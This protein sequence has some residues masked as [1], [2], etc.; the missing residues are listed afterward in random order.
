M[1]RK[2]VFEKLAERRLTMKEASL[3]MGRA[4]SYLYQFLKR[5]IP[6]ELHER[7]RIS[8]AAILEVPEGEL[9]GPSM[10]LPKR[11]Y[12]KVAAS[13]KSLIDGDSMSVPSSVESHPANLVSSADLFGGRH[14]LPVFGASQTEQGGQLIVSDAAVDWVARPAMLQ[15]VNDGYGLI[16]PDETMKPAHKSGSIALVNPHLPPRVDDSCVFRH[17]LADGTSVALIREYRGQTESVW[18]VRQYSPARDYT[19][20]KSDWPACHRMVGSYFP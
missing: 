10:S 3:K 17:R 18:K 19:I 13:R 9:R 2:L 6:L 16:I 8:L 12:E 1:V 14:D 7:D 5:G 4:H 15:R 20:K 11:N